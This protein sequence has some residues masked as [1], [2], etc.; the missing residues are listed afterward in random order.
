MSRGLVV[1][2]CILGLGGALGFMPGPKP[3]ARSRACSNSRRSGGTPRML[4]LE[5]SAG[6]GAYG[7][8]DPVRAHGRHICLD[9][10]GFLV[11][12]QEGGDLTLQLMRD[13]VREAGVREVHSKMVVLGLDGES[14]PGFT[15]VCLVDE[16]HVTAHCYSDRGWLAIDVFTCGSHPPEDIA[17]SLHAKLVESVP[18][19]RLMRGVKLDRFLHHQSQQHAD[20]AAAPIDGPNHHHQHEE[21]LVEDPVLWPMLGDEEEE[22]DREH[23][24]RV[25]A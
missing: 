24:W 10:T 19:L 14:P 6:G 7:P 4:F 13:A 2:A 20:M 17:T 15:A 9:Y 16:S 18:G 21:L 11:P 3:W 25:G 12:A 8:L 23:D 1:V 22:E 5:D